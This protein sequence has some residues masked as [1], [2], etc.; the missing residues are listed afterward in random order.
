[1][2]LH[3]LVLSLGAALGLAMIGCGGGNNGS[4][5]LPV[6]HQLVKFE[7]P[8]E[9]ELS[10]EGQDI[11]L[12]KPIPEETPPPREEPPPVPKPAPPAPPPVKPPAKGGKPQ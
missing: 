1:M 8:S 7:K 11:D 4:Y 3:R 2:K 5:H 9:A 12:T 10:G 6:D